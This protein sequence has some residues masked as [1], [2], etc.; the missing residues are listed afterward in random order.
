LHRP[1]D[2]PRDVV[3][4][5]A[6]IGGFEDL[7]RTGHEEDGGE[8]VGLAVDGHPGEGAAV[9]EVVDLAGTQAPEMAGAGEGAR[10]DADPGEELALADGEGRLVDG[11]RDEGGLFQPEIGG[12]VETEEAALAAL[13]AEGVEV[14]VTLVR[15]TAEGPDASPRRLAPR[16]GEVRKR[17]LPPLANGAV[18]PIGHL[19]GKL[20]GLDANAARKRIEAPAE[21]GRDRLAEALPNRA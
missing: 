16:R 20:S 7:G 19:R 4:A 11:A 13:A 6:E 5:L 8:E 9:G 21:G 12:A 10:V 15:K 2:F 3:G 1:G 17:E 14:P 18:D